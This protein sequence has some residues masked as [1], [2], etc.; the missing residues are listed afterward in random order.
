MHYDKFR[1]ESAEKDR[2]SRKAKGISKE[3][4]TNDSV[5]GYSD[6][7]KL[8]YMPNSSY[9]LINTTYVINKTT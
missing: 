6:S 7:D 5:L 1:E 3:N 2:S 4:Q 8:D 9:V